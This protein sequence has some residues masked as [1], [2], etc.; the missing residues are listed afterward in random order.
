MVGRWVDKKAEKAVGFGLNYRKL[1]IMTDRSIHPDFLQFL[2]QKDPQLIELYKQTRNL[3]LEVFPEANELLYHTHALTSVY[4][5]TLKMGNGF[6]HIP[7]YTNHLNLGFNFG[8]HLPDPHNL[9]AGTGKSIRHI[10]VTSFG[11]IDTE[12]VRALIHQAIQYSFDHL[13]EKDITRGQTISK[14]K[15]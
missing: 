15:S 2:E 12:E 6:V 11:D 9:L 3:V 8:A 14:I 1:K 7:M 13:R 4:T 10:P 5:P